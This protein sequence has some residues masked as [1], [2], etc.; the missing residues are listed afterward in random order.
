MSANRTK[1]FVQTCRVGPMAAAVLLA[2]NGPI[3]A[4]EDPLM[5]QSAPK[6][7]EPVGAVS[8]VLTTTQQLVGQGFATLGDPVAPEPAACVCTNLAGVTVICE[9][10]D[11][12]TR[13]EYCYTHDSVCQDTA[14]KG[15]IREHANFFCTTLAE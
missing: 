6:V 2:I 10:C 9:D 8:Q 3:F 14:Q 1:R 15:G 5:L 7:Y 4:Q 11:N 12:E 13:D